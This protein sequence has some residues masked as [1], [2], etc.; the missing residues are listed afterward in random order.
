MRPIL[1][2]KISLAAL[3]VEHWA[4]IKFEFDNK[5]YQITFQSDLFPHGCL[6]HRLVN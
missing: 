3:R 5:K 6:F 4:V 1:R 2:C